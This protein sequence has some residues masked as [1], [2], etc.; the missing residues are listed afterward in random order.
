MHQN[1][2]QECIQR[3]GTPPRRLRLRDRWRY[4]QVPRPRWLLADPQEPLHRLLKYQWRL[5]REG[6][7][8]WGCIIQANAQLFFPGE[9]NC[10]GE[11]LYSLE[12]ARDVEPHQLVEVA[13]RLQSLKGTKP[14]N[15]ALAEIAHYLTAELIRVFGLPVPEFLSPGLRCKLSTTLFVRK[16]LPGGMLARNILPVLV[17]PRQPHVALPL[18]ERFWPQELIAW[19]LE[20]I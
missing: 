16:H 9:H 4:L 12:N 3:F 19:W 5:Y 7:I 8:V 17:M 1:L 6:E 14:D 15:P 11:L 13:Y 2:L 20:G 18:P 10:P